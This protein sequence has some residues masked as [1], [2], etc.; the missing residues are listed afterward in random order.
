MNC[1]TGRVLYLLLKQNIILK[2]LVSIILI[3]IPFGI[4]IIYVDVNKIKNMLFTAVM[5]LASR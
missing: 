4:I 3:I 1:D 5:H 2:E